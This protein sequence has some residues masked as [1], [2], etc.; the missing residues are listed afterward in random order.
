MLAALLPLLSS[1]KFQMAL[2]AM[3][4]HVLARY[5][6]H[7][8]PAQALEFISPLLAAILGQGIADH[9]KAAAEVH[10]SLAPM[11]MNDNT[12]KTSDAAPPAQAA[13]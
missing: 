3:L 7:M 1:K 9:G 10:A 13:A 2:L 8:D 4:A 11:P 6:L 12:P 5:G